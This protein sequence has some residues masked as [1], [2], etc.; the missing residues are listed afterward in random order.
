MDRRHELLEV[1]LDLG[2]EAERGSRAT[3]DPKRP[4]GRSGKISSTSFL[5]LVPLAETIAP[6]SN[7][8]CTAYRRSRRREGR[9]VGLTCRSWRAV[10]GTIGILRDLVES[11][12]S[13]LM[14]GRPVLA[15]P[16]CFVRLPACWRTISRKRV[17]IVDTSNEIG[18]DGDIPHPAIG[19]ARRMQVMSRACSTRS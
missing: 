8:R 2:R 15:R 5:E 3:S 14:M 4:P 6:V 13:I 1:V 18:G 9:V 17:I 7:G 16:R 19:R 10:F 11:G 12:R